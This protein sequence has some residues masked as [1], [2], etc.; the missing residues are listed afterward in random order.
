[1]FILLLADQ[2]N[3]TRHDLSLFTLGLFQINPPYFIWSNHSIKTSSF[4]TLLCVWFIV[5]K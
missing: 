1:M 4:Q 2:P 3:P 5:Y